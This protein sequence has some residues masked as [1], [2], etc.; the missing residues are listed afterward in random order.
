MRKLLRIIIILTLMLLASALTCLI[1]ALTIGRDLGILDNRFTDVREYAA[2]LE[3]IED[4]YIGEYNKTEV[5]TAALRAAVDSLDDSWSY[6]FT[7]EE[8]AEYLDSSNNRFTGIGVNVVIDDETGGIR[9]QSI[10]K[11]SAASIAGILA[12]D[13][14]IAV[15]GESII[16]IDM[17]QLSALLS[18]P[19]GETVVLSVIRNETVIDEIAVEYGYVFLDPV[20][21]ELF[22][23]N[24]GYISLAN[25]DG[26]SGIAFISAVDQLIEMGAVSLVFDVRNNGGG[27]VSEM[28][29]ILDYLLPEGEIFVAVDKEGIEDIIESTSEMIDLPCVVLINRYSYSAAEYFAA[30]LSEYDYAITVGQKTTGKSRSQVTYRLPGGSAVHISTGQYLTKNRVSLYDTG[31]LTPDY[32]VDFTKDEML[33]FLSGHLAYED[34][35]Q[36]AASLNLLHQS[37]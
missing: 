14:I 31:G 13:V 17:D 20:S 25:F 1:L 24:I 27:R 33:L 34:D 29:L 2:L 36:L 9:I 35:P 6:Y 18:R 8:Y 30:T 7:S 22:E 19:I 5:K 16:G 4:T 32:E 12:D 21:F 3:R 11:N 28:T 37:N 26:G 23:G 15:D 10:Y